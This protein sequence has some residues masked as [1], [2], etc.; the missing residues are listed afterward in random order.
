MHGCDLV[1]WVLLLAASFVRHLDVSVRVWVLAKATLLAIQARQSLPAVAHF[2]SQPTKMQIGTTSV[3]VHT[4][5]AVGG[6]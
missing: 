2:R 1:G 5:L 6:S 3:V 4:L